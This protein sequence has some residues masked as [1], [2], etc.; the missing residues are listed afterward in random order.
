MF[1]LEEG[2]LVDHYAQYKAAIHPDDREAVEAASVAPQDA[3]GS[4]RFTHRV[5]WP[6]GTV[7]WLE[8][9]GR[10]I[11]DAQGN[12]VRSMGTVVDITERKLLEESLAQAQ[13]LEAI[14]RLA[15]GVAHDFNNLLTVILGSL[16]LLKYRPGGRA[17]ENIEQA[18]L[19]ASNLTQQLL[20][21][22]RRAVIRPR[23]VVLDDV[24]RATTSMLE[25][26]IGEDVRI[27]LDFSKTAW[28][29]RVDESQIQQ[30]V[31]NLA[32]NARDAMLEGGVLSIATHNETF[33]EG[34]VPNVEGARPGDYVVLSVSDTGLGMGPEVCRRVFEPFFTTKPV[35]KGTGLGL[36]MVF[37][38]VA[39][40]GGF[41]RVDSELG[42][43]STFR[44]HFPRV[45][46]EKALPR[47]HSGTV[48]T[49]AE[50]ILLV[51]DEQTVREVTAEILGLA[52][53]RV[54]VAESPRK[55]QQVWE[56]HRTEIDL[57]LTD[58]VMP[59]GSGHDL[60]DQL[61]KE[62]PLLPVLLMSG[63]DP[64]GRREL[65]NSELLR[66]PF[67]REALLEATRRMLD[68]EAARVSAD[69]TRI[70]N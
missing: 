2:T 45:A 36:A 17:L 28:S 64:E 48:R 46:A 37:G 56:A 5:V 63:Y 27:E 38:L 54:L 62:R 33:L 31:L 14:G 60:A 40:S 1:G 8:V 26:I 67:A 52:G 15:G 16:D 58:L 39:Q 35:G 43:G 29:V 4:L 32:T 53:Y 19:S 3:E 61:R 25:R 18:A 68:A 11:H 20:A 55:A 9:T 34:Q 12:Q 49:G 24:L 57:L 10:V 65:V 22:S 47:N 70:A 66:K 7:R 21:Y 44:L 23:V 69:L 6:D 51:E 42:R 30:I 50:T 59:D 13:K 41:I